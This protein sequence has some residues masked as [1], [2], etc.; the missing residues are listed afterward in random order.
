MNIVIWNM[1]PE[2]N[3]LRLLGSIE[4][5]NAFVCLGK[6]NSGF[7]AFNQLFNF[8]IIKSYFKFLFKKFFDSPHFI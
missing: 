5:M 3:N 8:R 1:Q 7:N 4:F 2:Y 6:D